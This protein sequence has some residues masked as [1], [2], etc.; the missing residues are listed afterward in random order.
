VRRAAEETSTM[1]SD[2]YD[3]VIRNAS[4][5]DGT[6]AAARSADVAIRGDRFAA[7]GEVQDAAGARVLDAHGLSLAPGFIDVHTHDDFAVV[8]H[9]EMAFKV[10]QGVTTVVVGNCGFGPAPHASASTSTLAKSLHPEDHIPEWQG[11]GGY[12]ERLSQD[13]PSL[14]V[15]HLV[16]H[17]T[18]RHATM[19]NEARPPTDRELDRMCEG[20]REG[21]AAGAL[22]LSS[23]LIYEPGRHA[24]TDELVSLASEMTGTGA[25]YA[26]H[27]RNE[28]EGL[29]EAVRET[30]E[31]GERAGVPV[32]ISHLKAAGR[33]NWGRVG[34]ALEL[35]DAAQARGLDATA[36]QYPY[37][38]G[39]TVLSEILQNEAMRASVS[40]W[41]ASMAADVTLSSA[42]SHPEWEGKTL[43]GLAES[44]GVSAEQMAERVVEEEGATA[45]VVVRLMDEGDVR[46]VLRHPSTMIGSDGL[47]TLKGKPHPRLYG[48]FPRVLGRYVRELGLLPLEE[49]VHRMTGFPA[50]KFGLADRGVVSAGA[51]AD[52]VLF[53]AETVIDVGTYEDPN[54]PP[55]GIAQVFVNGV[56]VVGDGMHTGARP[57]RVVGRA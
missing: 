16:G 30:L 53:D 14:N 39:S 50:R 31:I 54:R 36:D 33:T 11:F 47:P 48:T 29:L 43:E 19:G 46:D 35:I 13:P 45:T 52:F 5:I 20:V 18:I 51:L 28:A 40:R 15:A 6:G 49:A 2:R 25:L 55:T 24:S 21:L 32:Q 7:V 22:G 10:R 26:T 8:L 1:K 37:T 27:M 44:L 57:G 34:E 41:A 17:G 9:P 23:G 3:L 12:V 56:Q 38:S 4:L 42:P